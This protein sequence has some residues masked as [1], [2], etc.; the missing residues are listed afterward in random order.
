MFSRGGYSITSGNYFC[1]IRACLANDDIFSAVEALEAMYSNAATDKTMA[2]NDLQFESIKTLLVASLV[3]SNKSSSLDDLYYALLDQVRNFEVNGG[4]RNSKIPRIVLDSIVEAAGKLDLTDR[5]FATFQEY[6]NLFLITPD[7]HS[8]NSLLASV[9]CA[10][11]INML[12]LLSVFQDIEDAE[13]KSKESD[14]K[15]EKVDLKPN[16]TSY[17]LLFEAMVDSNDFRVFDA[18]FSHMEASNIAP[19]A[20]SMRRVIIAFAK[21]AASNP[22]QGLI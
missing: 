4:T 18:V 5:A 6:T 13:N 21:K 11:N 2:F 22:N 9:A 1:F 14:Q 15:L 12:T 8:Y 17:T 7:I 20:R 3:K 10:R 19:S 16:S